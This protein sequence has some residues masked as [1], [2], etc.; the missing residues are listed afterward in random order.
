MSSCLKCAKP[1][2]ERAGAG[3][4]PVYCGVGCRRAVE[5]EVRRLSR[6]LE[7]LEDDLLALDRRLGGWLT[8]D[9]AAR[10]TKDADVVRRQLAEAEA[11]LAVLLGAEAHDR[12]VQ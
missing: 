2:P 5:Y 11:R 8:K 6:R 1:L 10:L 3:R 9:Q 4:P 12:P 7:R